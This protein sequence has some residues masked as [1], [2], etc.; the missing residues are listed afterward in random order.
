MMSITPG[1]TA[2]QIHDFV[3]EYEL[4]PHGTRTAWR[5]ARGVSSKQ[6]RRWRAAVFGGDVEA[7]LV[8][9]EGCEMVSEVVRRQISAREA[10]HVTEVEALRTQIRELKGVNDALGKAIGLLHALN[11]QEPATMMMNEP[12]N[13]SVLKT[14]S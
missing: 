7:G 13:S 11:E 5:A 10:A 2:Q 1:W 9:R 3:Y 4:Q 12:K 8:P 14:S 6:L